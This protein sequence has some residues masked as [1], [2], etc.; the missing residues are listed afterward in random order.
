MEMVALIENTK[1]ITVK[2]IVN[3]SKF[4]L[5]LPYLADN[6]PL[7]VIDSKALN[8]NLF[9]AHTSILRQVFF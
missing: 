1:M 7:V 4:F 6:L 2:I 5:R 8:H 3:E 9:T